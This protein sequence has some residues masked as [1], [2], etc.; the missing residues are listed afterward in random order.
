MRWI[1]SGIALCSL[2]AA[3]GE[4]STEDGS[5]DTQEDSGTGDP[6]EGDD[7]D[8]PTGDDADEP[9][10]DDDD[11]PTDDDVDDPT[12]AG[13]SAPTLPP[14]PEPISCGDVDCPAPPLGT[15]CC[16]TAGDV[17]AGAALTKGA[18][19]VDLSALFGGPSACVEFDQPGELDESCPPLE[20]PDAPPLPGCCTSQGFCGTFDSFIGLGCTTPP[21]ESGEPLPCGEGGG[22]AGSSSSNGDAGMTSTP[23]PDAGETEPTDAGASSEPTPDAGMSLAEDAGASDASQ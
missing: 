22:D 3:C 2:L 17:R 16:A 5:D 15:P 11:E 14:P 1:L 7:A 18:C 9:T 23:S 12:D 21:P 6:A 19:G 8:E 20:I 4:S 13:S 10:A